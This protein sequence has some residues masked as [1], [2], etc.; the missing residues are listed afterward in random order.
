MVTLATNADYQ[1]PSAGRSRIRPGVDDLHKLNVT[2]PTKG[3]P[4]QGLNWI[5]QFPLILYKSLTSS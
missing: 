4:D 3:I 2:G 5:A 1:K